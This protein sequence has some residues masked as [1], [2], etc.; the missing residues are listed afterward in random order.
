M[1]SPRATPQKVPLKI[2]KNHKNNLN[3]TL[4]NTEEQKRIQ[5]VK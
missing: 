4:K 3:V 1:V 2:W 5:Q